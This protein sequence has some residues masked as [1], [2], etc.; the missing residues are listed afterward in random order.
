MLLMGLLPASFI[1]RKDSAETFISFT[2]T[3][4]LQ[5]YEAVPLADTTT[6]YSTSSVSCC[7]STCPVTALNSRIKK[8]QKFKSVWQY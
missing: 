5:Y 1:G 7:P 3:A 4:R 6:G 8:S 2:A